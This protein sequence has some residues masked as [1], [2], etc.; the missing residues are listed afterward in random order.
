MCDLWWG[1]GDNEA[2]GGGWFIVLES[3]H[4]RGALDGNISPKL[5][6]GEALFTEGQPLTAANL[7]TFYET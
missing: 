7:N 6:K 4:S 2:G 1:R 3:E 5:S